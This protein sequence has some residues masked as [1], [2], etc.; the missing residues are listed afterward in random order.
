MIAALL[1]RLF[2]HR[3]GAA[4][5]LRLLESRTTIVLQTCPR[6]STEHEVDVPAGLLVRVLGPAHERPRGF[7]VAW[8]R[9]QDGA[10]VCMPVPLNV[11]AAAVRRAWYWLRCPHVLVRDPRQAYL[12]GYAQGLRAGC[13]HQEPQP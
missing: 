1:C 2:G 12:E 6:C 9:W 3:R 13:H 11:L 5:E 8:Y 4:R 7:G 10:A